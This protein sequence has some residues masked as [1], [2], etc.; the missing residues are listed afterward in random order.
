MQRRPETAWERGLRYIHIALFS[1]FFYFIPFLLPFRVCFSQSTK[2][3]ILLSVFRQAKEMKRLSQQ[4]KETDTALIS[5]FFFQ[6]NTFSTTVYGIVSKLTS[7]YF[8]GKQK[9]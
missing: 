1:R 3:E 7:Y 8:S 2:I 9:K 4:R 6:F 5:R